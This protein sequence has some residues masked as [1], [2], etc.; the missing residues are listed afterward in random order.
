MFLLAIFEVPNRRSYLQ[1]QQNTC[2]PRDDFTERC[3]PIGLW[4]RQTKTDHTKLVILFV[5]TNYYCESKVIF[6]FSNNAA[7]NI[8]TAKYY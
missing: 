1:E 5:L 6:Y 8:H 3:G 7:E 4:S 2:D